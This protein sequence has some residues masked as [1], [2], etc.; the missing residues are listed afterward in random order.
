MNVS[1]FA[2]PDLSCSQN[3]TVFFYIN[4]VNV[5]DKEAQKDMVVIRDKIIVSSKDNLDSK[6]TVNTN[7]IYNSTRGLFNDIK[8]IY[9]QATRNL[10]GEQ[11]EYYNI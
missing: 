11:R 6:S 10:S 5:E 7:F 1:A 9:N 4:G 2:S 3:G 8:E